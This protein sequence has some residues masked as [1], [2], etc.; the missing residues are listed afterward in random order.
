MHCAPIVMEC[1]GFSVGL[2]GTQNACTTHQCRSAVEKQH[3]VLFSTLTLNQ[4]SFISSKFL[5]SFRYLIML[6]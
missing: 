4:K 1:Y 6:F 2:A 3:D 5:L